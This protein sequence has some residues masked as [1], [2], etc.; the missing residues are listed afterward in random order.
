MPRHPPN[1]WT[2]FS[3]HG[4]VLYHI[5]LDPNLT[6]LELARLTELSESWVRRIVDDLEKAD[7]IR[8]EKRG[9]QNHYTVNAAARLRH[10]TQ[11]HL[12]IADLVRGIARPGDSG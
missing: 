7:M 10:P 1:N 8:V 12:T 2:I 11:H 4:I 6:I 5:I 3:P 9:V